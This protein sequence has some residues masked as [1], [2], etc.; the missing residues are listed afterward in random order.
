M[1][2]YDD[3]ALEEYDEY[4]DEDELHGG[5]D[6][7][8]L[9]DEEFDEDGSESG[10]DEDDGVVKATAGSAGR[11][12]GAVSS[13]QDQE[14]DDS[15]N[16]LLDTIGSTNAD[17]YDQNA[18]A[19]EHDSSIVEDMAAIREDLALAKGFGG[20]RR[21]VNRRQGSPSIGTRRKREKRQAPEIQNL[22]AEGNVAYASANLAEAKRK[23]REIIRLDAT[24]SQAWLL[25]AQVHRE[26]GDEKKELGCRLVAAH[27]MHDVDAWRELAERSKESGHRQ[28]ALYCMKRAVAVDPNDVNVLWEQA[29]MAK[30]FGEDEQA[31][32]S[33]RRLLQISP[34]DMNILAEMPPLFASANAIQEG[35]QLFEAAMDYHIRTF[36][37]GPSAET[38]PRQT[39][40][41][42]TNSMTLDFIISLA[43]FKI[44]LHEYEDVI[45]IIRKGQR[46]LSGRSR[47]IYWDMEVDDREFDPPGT[48][49]Q[50]HS[51]PDVRGLPGGADGQETISGGYEM[52]INLRHR[53]A[54]AR[55]KLGN[56]YDANIHI[57]EVLNQD[58]AEYTVLWADIGVALMDR[59]LYEAAQP[60]FAELAENEETAD[61]SHV[62]N[63]GIC[64]HNLRDFAS[65]IECF[66][67]VIEYAPNDLDTKMKLAHAYE[68]SGNPARALEIVNDVREARKQLHKEVASAQAAPDEVMEAAFF[69]ESA[70]DRQARLARQAKLTG[71]LNRKERRELEEEEARVN[72]ITLKSDERAALAGD[73]AAKRRYMTIADRMVTGM[74]QAPVMFPVDR[75]VK[76]VALRKGSK[77][78]RPDLHN[79]DQDVQDMADRLSKEDQIEEEDDGG[80]PARVE[81]A[82]GESTQLVLKVLTRFQGIN[83]ETWLRI[84]MLFKMEPWWLLQGAIGTGVRG[85]DSFGNLN[86]QKFLI[87]EIRVWDFIANGGKAYWNDTFTRWI[88]NL[89]DRYTTSF[90]GK[91]SGKEKPDNEDMN[92]DD[93]DLNSDDEDNDD[94]DG[95]DDDRD[96]D[97]AEAAVRGQQSSKPREA[98][99][100]TPWPKPVDREPAFWLMYGQAL[101]IG[102]SYQGSIYYLLRSYDENPYDPLTCL[103]LAHAY[104][105]RSLQRQSD[106]R[107]HQITTAMAFMTRYRKLMPNNSHWLKAEE[108]AE[109]V[110]FNFGR[111]FQGLGKGMLPLAIKHYHRVLDSVR[112]R[113]R[114]DK[115]NGGIPK[116]PSIGRE[117]AYNLQVIFLMTGAA[118]LCREVTEEW[119][120]L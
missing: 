87:R 77:G 12:R 55:L 71:R 68:D 35:A 39:T 1:D 96:A 102:K 110:D 40:N 115:E 91:N 34:H 104:L 27:L 42:T 64:Q 65:A 16:A 15:F 114:A 47:E 98:L 105:G 61:L 9:D 36:P 26:E 86:V 67:H 119:L 32:K 82:R 30:E 4:A 63:L 54:I 53:L 38:Q 52:D 3:D 97:A 2:L 93:P 73:E 78:K 84:V 88:V 103:C 108:I 23:F 85:W 109:E 5:D 89:K 59:G 95:I 75:S 6:D 17:L 79:M 44:L 8:A 120:G 45:N 92:Q 81:P 21:R 117:A 60:I 25:L 69:N 28:Q 31:L 29:M 24:E 70:E 48:T 74:R 76:W 33:F 13:R 83:V 100:N 113:M 18:L 37:D 58:A 94:E 41:T 51:H 72:L 112:T 46:W 90:L 43:D 66:E 20:K 56:D 49:R 101:L 80:E 14:E 19:A 11:G 7:R 22:F 50:S 10:D 118:A 116:I 99:R 57:A 107:L 106:N 111:A 62:I